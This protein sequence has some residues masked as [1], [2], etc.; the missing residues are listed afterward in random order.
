VTLQPPWLHLAG[1]AIALGFIGLGLLL[2]HYRRHLQQL[3]EWAHAAD[4]FL[5]DIRRDFFTATPD[6]PPT[7]TISAAIDAGVQ[8]I[9]DTGPPTVQ[10]GEWREVRIGTEVRRFYVGP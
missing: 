1:V 9:V 4:A 8:Q 5:D 10:S 3:T 6:E 2:D 7:D